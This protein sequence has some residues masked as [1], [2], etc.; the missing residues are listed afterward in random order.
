MLINEGS[1]EK[2]NYFYVPI[3]FIIK[4]YPEEGQHIHTS[5]RFCTGKVIKLYS[6]QSKVLSKLKPMV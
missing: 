6:F 5:H 2:I 4:F 1:A 3:I